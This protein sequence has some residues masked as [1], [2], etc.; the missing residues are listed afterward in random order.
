MPLSY[1]LKAA[2]GINADSQIKGIP[3]WAASDRY[4]VEIKVNA[5]TADVWNK[6]TP[7]QQSKLEEPIVRRVLADRCMLRMHRETRELPVYDLVILKGGLKMKE[8]EP[9]EPQ[10][11][12]WNANNL[13]TAI[14]A[15]AVTID[16][17]TSNLTE[18]AGRLI[19]DKTGLGD[20]KF[21]FELKWSSDSSH[22][23]DPADASPSLFTAF[24]EQLG[25]KLL[26]SKGPVEVVVID[27]L[28]KPSPN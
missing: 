6:S 17:L 24:E 20:K 2:Y 19:I 10:S 5:E 14:S 8:S 7:D 1:L 12:A 23:T 3:D 11:Y 4:D 25:L 18:T 22:P 27:H 28:E 26:P 13:G 15:H 16:D 9:Q 21:D